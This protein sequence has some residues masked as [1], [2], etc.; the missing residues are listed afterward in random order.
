MANEIWH[1]YANSSTLYALI[2]RDSDKYIYVT[3]SSTFEAVGTW[4]NTRAGQC[5]IAMTATG[6]M[7]FA[8]FPT[9]AA[10][11]YNV[12]VR[13]QSGGSPAALDFPIAQ[14]Q[15]IWDGTTEILI[16]EIEQSLDDVEAKI[17]IIDTN[18]DTV[19][20]DVIIIDTNVDALLLASGKV[21]ITGSSAST[22]GTP[23][24]GGL[25]PFGKEEE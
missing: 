8:N 21:Q 9:V 16:S 10:G 4:N 1:S 15:M 17:D 22:G 3:G 24:A 23:A 25:I 14:G 7:F 18:V 5:A 20:A 12:E 13:L 11:T 6:D 2:Y 19:L